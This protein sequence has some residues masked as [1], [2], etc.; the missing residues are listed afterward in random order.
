LRNPEELSWWAIEALEHDSPW[1]DKTEP[2][3]KLLAEIE[4]KE[5]KHA[6]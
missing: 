3:K 1:P 6:E 5:N 4:G 2:I